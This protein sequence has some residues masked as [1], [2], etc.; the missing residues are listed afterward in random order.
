[1]DLVSYHP[2]PNYLNTFPCSIWF[3]C[4]DQGLLSEGFAIPSQ[5]RQGTK[6]LSGSYSYGLI[7]RLRLLSTRPHGPSQLPLTT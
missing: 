3:H 4:L 7:I 1:M 6:P 2:V 5:T